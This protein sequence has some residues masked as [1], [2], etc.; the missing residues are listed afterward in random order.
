LEALVHV[1]IVGCGRVGSRLAVSLDRQGH[2]VAVVD[3]SETAFGRLGSAFG[4]TKVQG[5]GFDRA[6]LERADVAQ[7]DAVAAVTSGDNSNIVIARVAREAFGVERVVARIYDT[8]RAQIV[9]RMGIPTVATVEWSTERV[10]RRIL[11]AGDEPVWVAPSATARLIESAAPARW[12]GRSVETFEEEGGARIA[13][14]MRAGSAVVP[15]SSTVIQ[16]GDVLYLMV[17]DRSLEAVGA[18][19]SGGQ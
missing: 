17:E 4:G 11:P 9:E 6:V 3:R 8:E 13:A 15:S 12:A 7:A 5:V 18:R 10:L 14:L 1:V 16:D 2:S 19:L